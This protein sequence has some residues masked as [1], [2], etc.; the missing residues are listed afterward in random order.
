MFYDWALSDGI[1]KWWYL[2]SSTYPNWANDTTDDQSGVAQG[3][4]NFL[5]K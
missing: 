2:E 5:K 4:Y 3:L 1:G